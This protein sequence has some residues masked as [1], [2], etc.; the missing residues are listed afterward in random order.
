MLPDRVDT[1]GGLVLAEEVLLAPLEEPEVSFI[2]LLEDG[3]GEAAALLSGGHHVVRLGR[4][5]ALNHVV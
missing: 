2:D 1:L 4:G 5:V 3:E